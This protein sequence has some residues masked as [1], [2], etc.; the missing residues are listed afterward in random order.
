[1]GQKS[2]GSPENVV[3]NYSRGWY[4][5]KHAQS[6]PG[7]GCVRWKL[8]LQSLVQIFNGNELAYSYQRYTNAN[9]SAQRSD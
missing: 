5:R 2:F 7:I 6:G 9:S 1:L 4:D 3:Y 8:L